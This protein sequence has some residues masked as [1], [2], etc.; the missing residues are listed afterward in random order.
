MTRSSNLVGK[1]VAQVLVAIALALIVQGAF[2]AD[3]CEC[4][5]C[6]AHACMHV[7]C[8]NS[9]DGSNCATASSNVCRDGI[10]IALAPMTDSFVAL[11]F[12]PAILIVRILERDTAWGTAFTRCL[13]VPPI[14]GR[15]AHIVLCRLRR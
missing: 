4:P 7:G 2:A 15:S 10:M 3:T 1:H 5:S 8:P 6:P 13:I 9:D 14:V 11:Y 12:A